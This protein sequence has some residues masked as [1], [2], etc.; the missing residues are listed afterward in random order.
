MKMNVF[1][2]TTDAIMTTNYESLHA[3][4]INFVT[5]EINAINSSINSNN[6]IASNVNVN[7]KEILFTD[8]TIYDDVNI[9]IKLANVTTSY[10]NL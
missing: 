9:R 6:S 10:S 5:H 2:I 4:A 1:I 7:L 8:I 3:S